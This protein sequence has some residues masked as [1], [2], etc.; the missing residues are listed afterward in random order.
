MK[1]CESAGVQVKHE[2]I[3]VIHRTGS[4]RNQAARPVLVKFASRKTKNRLLLKKKEF[5]TKPELKRVYLND[6]LTPLR[7]KLLKICKQTP[8]VERV[9]TTH[10]GKIACYMKPTPGSSSSN[11]SEPSEK[12]YIKSPDDLCDSSYWV[13][14]K[15][16][17]ST[18]AGEICLQE[19][20][21]KSLTVD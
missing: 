3:S 19:N 1:I 21:T 7:L 20:M 6:H 11:S 13:E 18:S 15:S 14:K 2:D 8:G 10:D 4:K 17:S 16:S 5:K 9:S 12:K